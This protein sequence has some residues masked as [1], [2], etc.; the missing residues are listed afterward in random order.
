LQYFFG[1]RVA[2]SDANAGFACP[3]RCRNKVPEA[4]CPVLDWCC[5]VAP[6]GWIAGVL[7]API[8]VVTPH[9]REVTH[10]VH[11][12]AR[13]IGACVVVF[14]YDTF[15]EV[16]SALAGYADAGKAI[17]GAFRSVD[18]WPTHTLTTAKPPTNANLIGAF[19]AVVWAHD[20]F[21]RVGVTVRKGVTPNQRNHA[22]RADTQKSE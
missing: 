7:G 9:G 4:V 21:A 20:T 5:E 18:R 10:P 11:V 3:H 19:V 12:V 1:S 16:L 6:I 2:G 15:A 13:V 17:E 14:A 8:A 22:Q